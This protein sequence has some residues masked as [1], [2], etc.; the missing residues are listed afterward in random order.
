M[1]GEILPP[2]SSRFAVRVKDYLKTNGLIMFNSTA[3]AGSLHTIGFPPSPLDL[4]SHGLMP[5]FK[6][7]L[8]RR[9]CG[10]LGAF[11]TGKHNGV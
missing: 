9:T 7:D 8:F 10:A 3:R 5:T 6:P 1:W 4:E 2:P 11:L